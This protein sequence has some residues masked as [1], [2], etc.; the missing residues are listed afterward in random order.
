MDE[1]YV[2]LKLYLL[3]LEYN[4]PIKPEKILTLD[5]E[6]S[7]ANQANEIGLSIEYQKD[8]G[9]FYIDLT[10]TC[11]VSL[12]ETI[13]VFSLKATCRGVV[14]VNFSL[15]ED[16]IR[17]CLNTLVPQELYDNICDIVYTVTE[18]SGFQPIE[19]DY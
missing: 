17:E 2:I 4:S 5:K 8:S 15:P 10:V 13:H 6:G 9:L 19:M 18:N 12:P 1:D 3:N 11:D 14:A 16:K 7:E